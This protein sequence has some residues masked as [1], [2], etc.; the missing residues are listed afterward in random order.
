MTARTVYDDAD[1]AEP[2]RHGAADAARGA[3][4]D[5]RFHRSVHQRPPVDFSRAIPVPSSCRRSTHDRAHVAADMSPRAD[6]SAGLTHAGR[7]RCAVRNG[8]HPAPALVSMA[9]RSSLVA[10]RAA[11][12]MLALIVILSAQLMV[13]LDFSIVNV[14]A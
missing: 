5:R 7:T 9:N 14:P 2:Q 8:A 11:P 10:A 3:R 1:A 13:V 12:S 6:M 4:H